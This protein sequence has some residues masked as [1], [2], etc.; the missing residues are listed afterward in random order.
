MN[1]NKELGRDSVVAGFKVLYE[2]LCEE[3]RKIMKLLVNAL[4]AG[5]LR[6]QVLVHIKTSLYVMS[7][8]SNKLCVIDRFNDS[9]NE[10]HLYGHVKHI[11]S[12]WCVKHKLCQWGGF[13]QVLQFFPVSSIPRI[14]D[15]PHSRPIW[16]CG[17]KWHCLI[18]LSSLSL[19]SY[20]QH[21]VNK[22]VFLVILG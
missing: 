16:G 20:Y 17:A 15:C 1:T 3:L 8:T 13:L 6:H 7:A 9:C 10:C 11:N 5:S 4:G 18:S 21:C 12:Q 19:P 2:Y 22:L 14:C